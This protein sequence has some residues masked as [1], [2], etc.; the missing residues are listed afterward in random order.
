MKFSCLR[1]NLLQGMNSA[2]GAVPGRTALPVLTNFLIRA[3]GGRVMITGNDLETAIT[4]VVKANVERD[5]VVVIPAK[6]SNSFVGSLADGVLEVSDEPEDVGK[7]GR[8]VRITSGRTTSHF[9]CEDAD[10]YPIPPSVDDQII[11]VRV[12]AK[13]FASGITRVYPAIASR[14]T[15]PVLTGMKM[16]MEGS[17]FTLAAA[18]GFRLAI[19]E[20]ELLEDVSVADENAVRGI[21]IPG[22]TAL[23]L[24]KLLSAESGDVEVSVTAAH[25]IFRM[26]DFEV[27]SSVISGDFPLYRRLVPDSWDTRVV[28][29]TRDLENAVRSV[30]VFTERGQSPQVRLVAKSNG[31]G[32]CVLTVDGQTEGLGF[33]SGEMPVWL[34]GSDGRAAFS[35][36]YLRDVLD[37]LSGDIAIELGSPTNPGVLRPVADDQDFSY[38]HVIMPMSVTW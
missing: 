36:K 37:V 1:A 27:S 23:E 24:R 18:D 15:R 20:A 2:V 14:D 13:V 3:R 25:V 6:M 7:G 21:L 38:L 30:S 10:H 5:G 4:C 19:F 22:K 35:A 16:E 9:S 33:G 29:G 31:D 11:S 8:R 12:S 26:G 17:R 32:G 34:E 28:V